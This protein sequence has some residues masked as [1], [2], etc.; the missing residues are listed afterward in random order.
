MH[1][2]K[3]F[4]DVI[5]L[6]ELF[7]SGGAQALLASAHPKNFLPIP[8]KL[9]VYRVKVH[10][11]TEK[12]VYKTAEKYAVLPL[13]YNHPEYIDEWVNMFLE[14]YRSKNKKNFM[15]LELDGIEKLGTAV[16]TIG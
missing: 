15:N 13:P 12:G 9:P 10:F 2:N 14:D 4:N 7:V 5:M 16:L 8:V 6:D 11:V 1:P 3:F